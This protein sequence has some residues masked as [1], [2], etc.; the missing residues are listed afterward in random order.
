MRTGEPGIP[1]RRWGLPEQGR[2]E[3]DPLLSA[4]WRQCSRLKF[5]LTVRTI[6]RCP[7]QYV[8]PDGFGTGKHA[9]S[10]NVDCRQS[11][12]TGNDYVQVELESRKEAALDIFEA[13]SHEKR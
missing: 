13:A 9:I 1:A 12:K 7:R 3:L 8:Q 4:C 2:A 6:I 5:A 11:S 10:R